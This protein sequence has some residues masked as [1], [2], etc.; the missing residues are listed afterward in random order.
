[1]GNKNYPDSIYSSSSRDWS[2]WGEIDEYNKN[3]PFPTKEC[4]HF[5]LGK[6]VF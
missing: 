1:M 5:I 6:K 2:E 3:R 4:E